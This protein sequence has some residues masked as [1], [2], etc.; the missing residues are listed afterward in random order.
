MGPIIIPSYLWKRSTSRSVTE[1]ADPLEAYMDSMS[2]FIE[3]MERA[4]ELEEND[5]VDLHMTQRSSPRQPE[6]KIKRINYRHSA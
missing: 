4:V 3:G 6:I 5:A 1:T 2:R